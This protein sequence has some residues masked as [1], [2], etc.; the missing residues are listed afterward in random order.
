MK[1][2]EITEV[3]PDQGN[4]FVPQGDKTLFELLLTQIDVA[5]RASLGFNEWIVPRTKA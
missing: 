4:D 1:L 2:P 5:K 3:N